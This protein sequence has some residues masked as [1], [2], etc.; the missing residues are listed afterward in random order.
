MT[1]TDTAHDDVEADLAAC[2]R[3]IERMGWPEIQAFMAEPGQSPY[4]DAGGYLLR[5]IKTLF[6]IKPNRLETYREAA[7]R[8][9]AEA[10]A[11]GGGSHHI[12]ARLNGEKP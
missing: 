6:G 12:D 9:V 5:K 7:G 4:E 2:D 10:R 1:N 11:Q 3:A 8:L